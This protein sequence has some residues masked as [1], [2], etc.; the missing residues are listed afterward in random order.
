MTHALQAVAASGAY[1]A[2]GTSS[3]STLVFQLP[4]PQGPGGQPGQGPGSGPQTPAHSAHSMGSGHSTLPGGA[5]MWQLGG[6]AGGERGVLGFDPVSSLGFSVVGSTADALWLAVGH[7]SG[8]LTVWELQK[9]GPRQVAG[10]G[11]CWGVGMLSSVVV[12][13]VKLRHS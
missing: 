8:A 4:V 2:V 5:A 11:E 13:G 6:P 3:G 10:I 12:D 7:V 1:L 9:R